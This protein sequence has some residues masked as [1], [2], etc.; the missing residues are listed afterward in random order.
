MALYRDQ[1]VR[2]SLRTI[3]ARFPP[4]IWARM[5]AVH[6]EHQGARVAVEIIRVAAPGLPSGWRSAM[7]CPRCSV[8][9]EVVGCVPPN[10]DS[11]PGWACPRC[12]KWRGRPRR[13]VAAP[14]VTERERTVLS[15]S[16]VRGGP[17]IEGA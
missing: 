5:T 15:R 4:R 2:L 17:G 6:L 16:P 11:E 12:T 1:V 3:R 10:C 7:R 9:V 13:V 14:P 8:L